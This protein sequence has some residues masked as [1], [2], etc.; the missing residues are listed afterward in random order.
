MFFIKHPIA[1]N[2]TIN[3]EDNEKNLKVIETH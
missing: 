3:Q 1:L 2:S